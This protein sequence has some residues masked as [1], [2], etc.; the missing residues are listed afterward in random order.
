MSTRR[1]RSCWSHRARASAG[2]FPRAI[3]GP[4]SART[5]RP[6][7][8][9]RRKKPASLAPVC[10]TPLGSYRIPGSAGN[11]A[12]LMVDVEVFPLSGQPGAR[13]LEG[14]GASA[15][16]AGFGLADAADAVDE[17]DL[18]DLIRS[19]SAPVRNSAAR[20][21]EAMLDRGRPEIEDKSHV[22]LVPAP[23][24]QAGQFLRAVRG[25]RCTRSWPGP[26]RSARLLSGRRHTL[27]TSAR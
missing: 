16:A 7:Q 19:L 20:R 8:R 24:A 13:R 11:G 1:S 18:R 25:A 22:R 23:A 4:A 14:S 5:A 3:P 15:S 9:R 17:T 10:P 21:G 26:T 6:L 12:S 27:I 2:S